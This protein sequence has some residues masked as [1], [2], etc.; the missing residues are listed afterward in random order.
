[1]QLSLTCILQNMHVIMLMYMHVSCHMHSILSRD[2]KQGV[3]GC[4]KVQ[5]QS[6]AA[7][8]QTGATKRFEIS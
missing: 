6:E 4:K 3:L 5:G 7:C 8:K 1:M 2:V